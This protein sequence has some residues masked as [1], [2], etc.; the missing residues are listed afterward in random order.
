MTGDP[1]PF[2]LRSG[3][4]IALRDGTHL[5][6]TL[7]VPRQQAEPAPC[8][9]TLTPYIA[10]THHERGV[11]FAT[12][13][14]PFLIVDVRGRGNSEGDF[15]PYIQEADDGYDVVEWLATQPYCNGKISMWGSSYLGYAQWVTAKERP[16]HLATIVP[17]A[18][19]CIAVDF[20][21]RNNV[22]YP[23]LV[24]LLSFVAGRASQVKI[25]SDA[26]L[27]SRLFR[28][29]HETG[30]AFRELDTLLTDRQALLREWLQHSEP[31]AYWD[32]YNPTPAQYAQIQIPVLTIT[33]SYDDDQPGALE[34]Y[35][36]HLQHASPSAQEQ[37][38]LVIGPWDH[39]RTAGP[40]A[41]FGGLKF[42]PASL[43]D[44]MQLHRE[45][46][47]WRMQN[48]PQPEFLRKRVAYYVMGAERWRYADT[49]D[50]VTAQHR[51]YYLDSSGGAANDV[52]SAGL[53][54]EGG[55]V[56]DPDSYF[57]D[58]R[59]S[60]G[61]EIEAEARA[62]GSSLVDQ[63][64]LLALWGK[65][66]IYHSAPFAQDTEI[67]GFFR[68]SV[69]I[70]IDCPDTDFYVSVHEIALDG[71]SIRLSTDV[72]RARYREGLRTPRLI[73]TREP[74]RY[75][76][77][78][79]TFVS[80]QVGRGHRLRLVIAPMGRIIESTFVQKNYNAGGYVAGE[81]REEGRPVTV[82][83]FHDAVRPSVL[84]VPLGQPD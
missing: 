70:A 61:P 16:P 43:V 36:R 79:F 81:S 68:L 62:D 41:E 52:F 5:S 64:V 17:T 65:S 37:H 56:G 55:G 60:K 83:L 75:D 35:R 7:Y 13:G 11:Y 28:E 66:L 39:M 48:G 54:G 42:G 27:W 73:Q 30:R 21:M 25:F 34:H 32:A 8:I 23:F 59:D 72:M 14:L 33:G 1:T 67:S 22:S 29:W 51:A 10:D 15:R 80:R 3:V 9:F 57:Y 69:W 63:S 2:H 53:L 50:S 12:R 78:R 84:H 40:R 76:F 6:A 71:S 82:T 19:P 31:D 4:R 38:Y 20:P 47:A 46:Y 58:P 77:E 18:A 74:L 24:Q 45:W 49:L 44:I 26:R